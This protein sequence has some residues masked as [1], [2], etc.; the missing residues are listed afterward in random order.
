MLSVHKVSQNELYNFKH[1]KMS[2]YKYILIK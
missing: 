1:W 2:M